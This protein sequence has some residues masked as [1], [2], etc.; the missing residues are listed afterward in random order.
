MP[1]GIKGALSEAGV[2]TIQ[3]DKA[4]PGQALGS[5]LLSLHSFKYITFA[6]ECLRMKGSGIDPCHYLL[7]PRLE[8][9]LAHTAFW[10]APMRKCAHQMVLIR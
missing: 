3:K 8:R 4:D 7:C 2:I 9:K 6:F 10:L 1:V 5:N